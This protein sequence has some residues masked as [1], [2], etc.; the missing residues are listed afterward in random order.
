MPAPLVIT[1]KY[2]YSKKKARFS[3]KNLAGTFTKGTKI[4]MAFRPY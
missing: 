3:N 4:K 1:Q 2:K